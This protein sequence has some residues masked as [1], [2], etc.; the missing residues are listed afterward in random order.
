MLT[1]RPK[2]CNVIA[3]SHAAIGHPLDCRNKN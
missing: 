2:V 3:T 1:E